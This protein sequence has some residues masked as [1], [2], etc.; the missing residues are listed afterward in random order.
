[1]MIVFFAGGVGLLL[2]NDTHPIRAN[3]M[4]TVARVRRIFRLL[5]GNVR[6]GLSNHPQMWGIYRL[7]LTGSY[8]PQTVSLSDP[9]LGIRPG[10]EALRLPERIHLSS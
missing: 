6:F 7:L 10:R 5:Q 1:M 9:R 4:S 2:L 3:G 8:D